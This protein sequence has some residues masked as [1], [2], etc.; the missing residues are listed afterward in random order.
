MF[1]TTQLLA[2]LA[3][4]S[5]TA[6]AS[7]NHLASLYE[8]SGQVRSQMALVRAQAEATFAPLPAGRLLADDIF[9]E[10]DDLCRRL[11]RFEEQIS[12]I[13]G[14]RMQ[15]RRMERLVERIDEQACEVQEE[16]QA[17]L[18]RANRRFARPNPA[19]QPTPAG[20]PYHHFA[21]HT[22]GHRGVRVVVAG[23]RFSLNIGGPSFQALPHSVARS[24]LVGLQQPGVLA[25]QCDA[26]TR[27]ARRLRLMTQQLRQI[28]CG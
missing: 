26:L 22:V 20:F 24:H 8:F 13:P 25:P 19:F 15:L 12:Q 1:Q 9:D 4:A 7:A 14:T 2:L 5:I 10:L 21:R 17:A 3:I 23:G 6:P 11:D 18:E 27:Q 28:V 16:V